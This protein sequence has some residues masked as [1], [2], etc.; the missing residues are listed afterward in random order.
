MSNNFFKIS[1]IL[2]FIASI[3]CGSVRD[4]TKVTLINRGYKGQAYKPRD[5]N[6]VLDHPDFDRKKPTIIYS[7]GFTETQFQPSVRNVIDAYLE[8]NGFNFMIISCDSIIDYTI[9]NANE[10]AQMV[11]EGIKNCFDKG[12]RNFHLVGFSL[13]GQIVGM[14]GRK[15][16]EMSQKK[17]KIPRITGLDPGKVP[18]F[19]SIELL[20]QNDAEFVDIIHTETKYLGSA[21]S[22][23]HV[24]FWVNGGHSQPLCKTQIDLL[25]QVCSHLMAPKLWAESVRS[26]TTKVFPAL[27]CEKFSDLRTKNC[28]FSKINYMGLH[29][30]KEF[31]GNFYLETNNLPPYSRDL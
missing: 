3:N 19:F 14:I 24:I 5:L 17:Y 18:P 25:T 15:V 16:S 8:N 6:K 28:D 22:M 9:F 26:N 1:Y 30:N 31:K 10:I 23:G 2:F 11:A 20:N 27:K 12:Y 7:Y 21:E 13:G 4:F 29:A